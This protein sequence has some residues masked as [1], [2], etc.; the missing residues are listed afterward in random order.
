MEGA[1]LLHRTKEKARPAPSAADFSRGPV[2]RAG[3]ADCAGAARRFLTAPGTA[4]FLIARAL[5]PFSDFLL[6]PPQ[7][8]TLMR[9]SIGLTIALILQLAGNFGLVW[10]IVV[11][12]QQTSLS[13][14]SVMTVKGTDT[15]VQTANSD[16]LI[17]P[18]GSMTMRSLS[19]ASPQFGALTNSTSSSLVV[20]TAEHTTAA[21]FS[22][23]LPDSVFD[24]MLYIS[25]SSPTGSSVRLSVLGRARIVGPGAFGSVVEILT[26]AG[27][28]TLDGRAMTFEDS[29]APVFTRAGFNV[30]PAPGG[31]RLLQ[32][33]GVSLGASPLLHRSA[34]QLELTRPPL[35]HSRV[36]QLHQLV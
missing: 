26:F 13:S 35:F 34:A 2:G 22:S 16:F 21:P 30:G 31:R 15:P 23:V 4:P 14:G 3:A 9:V 5:V 10:S 8:R 20:Q 6:P 17:S 7:A 27:T 1:K 33:E 24:Q 19:D 32:N 36:L 18:T 29:V 11:A 12:N 25:V 28:I